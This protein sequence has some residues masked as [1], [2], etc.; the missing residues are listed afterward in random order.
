MPVPA[1]RACR[2]RW[3][4]QTRVLKFIWWRMKRLAGSPQPKGAAAARGFICSSSSKLLA[5]QLN[6]NIELIENASVKGIDGVAGNFQV[7][8]GRAAASSVKGKAAA[9]KKKAAE[10]LPG[11][12]AGAVIFAPGFNSLTA[13]QA[14]IFRKSCAY[15]PKRTGSASPVQKADSTGGHGSPCHLAARN[16]CGRRQP[17]VCNEV[18]LSLK[19]A[20]QQRWP[21]SCFPLRAARWSE[22]KNI[23]RKKTLP[24]RSPRSVFLC[25][26]SCCPG[27]KQRQAVLPRHASCPGGSC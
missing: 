24:A 23:L 4:W 26:N 19:A 17:G 15:L 7:T 6:N 11:I 12:A 21:R 1:L 2:Q 25:A 3:T 16:I 18:P 22:K 9:T 20:A 8:L 5:V 10:K 27:K 14:T 13:P